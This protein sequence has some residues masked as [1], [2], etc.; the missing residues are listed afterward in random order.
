MNRFVSRDPS[1]EVGLHVGICSW[2]TAK[3]EAARAAW[4]ALGTALGTA[5][6]PRPA[7]SHGPRPGARALGSSPAITVFSGRHRQSCFGRFFH[8]VVRL[9]LA[10]TVWPPSPLQQTRLQ[11]TL[12]KICN[13]GLLP[14]NKRCAIFCVFIAVMLTRQIII[15]IFHIIWHISCLLLCNKPSPKPSSLQQAFVISFPW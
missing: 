4:R 1:R 11:G 8:S 5:L 2:L 14:R 12:F 15:L 3:G 6:G 7:F 9:S 10:C 13:H